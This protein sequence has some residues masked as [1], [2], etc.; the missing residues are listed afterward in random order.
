M[1]KVGL[2]EFPNLQA[3]QQRVAARLAVQS[4]LNSEGLL[5]R[6]FRIWCTE[7]TLIL[8]W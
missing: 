1:L 4:A 8:W 3:F 7:R 6:Y 2:S 5:H